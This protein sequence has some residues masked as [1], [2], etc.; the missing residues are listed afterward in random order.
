MTGSDVMS[1]SYNLLKRTVTF[2]ANYLDGITVTSKVSDGSTVGAAMP[3]DP[4]RGDYVFTGW[5]TAQDGSGTSFNGNTVVLGDITVYAQWRDKTPEEQASDLAGMLGAASVDNGTVTLGAPATLESAIT[6]PDGVTLVTGANGLTLAAGASVTVGQG[7]ALVISE[8]GSVSGDGNITVSAGGKV[9]YTA[10]AQ[11]DF[12]NLTGDGNLLFYAGSTFA[13]TEGAYTYT[14]LGST[15]AASFELTDGT[16]SVSG[17]AYPTFTL[18]GNAVVGTSA[19]APG[20][21]GGAA[22]LANHTFVVDSGSTLTVPAGLTLLVSGTLTGDGA[23]AVN[24]SIIGAGNW[25]G[26]L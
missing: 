14:Y 24:G 11:G 5:N 3:S 19:G 6:I 4:S 9:G 25:P 16:I 17:A 15:D 18:K 7:G 22:I 8:N 2:N 20:G 21:G 10:T 13:I 12:S 1:A 26:K 23:I